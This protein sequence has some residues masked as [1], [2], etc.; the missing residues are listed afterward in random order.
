MPNIFKETQIPQQKLYDSIPFPAVLSPSVPSPSLSLLVDSIKAHKPFL[1]SLLFNTGAILFRGFPI[2]TASDFNDV[3]E[4]FG[5][6]ELPYSGGGAPRTHVVGR[7]YTANE[8]SL[9]Q[10]IPFH[11]EMNRLP[12]FPSKLF[13][14]CEVE[15]TSGGETPL[16]VSHI[17]YNRI[18]ERYPDFVKR[19]EDTGLI[20]TR[21][22]PEENDL[23]SPIGR[24]WRL[25]Y[26]TQDKS[27]AEER[28]AKLMTRLEWLEDGGVKA[29]TGPLPAIRYDECRDRKIW[30]NGLGMVNNPLMEMI[31]GDGEPLPIDIVHD[32]LKMLEEEGV[33]IPWQRGDVMLLD[34]LAV[35]HARKSCTTPRRVLASLCK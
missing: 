26:S 17:V 21:I 11:H 35:L 10:S 32:C 24:G 2:N 22:L 14:F 5:Y 30:F 16:A 6:E 12:V 13:F 9:D 1:E 33:A 31:F 25:T 20:Y 4:A 3:V 15:P 7:V 34:N 23:S 29:I 28:A 27:V 18:K 8:A 19:L